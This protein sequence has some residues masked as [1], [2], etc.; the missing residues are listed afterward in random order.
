MGKYLETRTLLG[1][2]NDEATELSCFVNGHHD[3]SLDVMEFTDDSLVG[4]EMSVVKRIILN[5]QSAVKLSRML[6]SQIG[7]MDE[8]KGGNQNG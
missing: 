7:K 2:Q 5:R 1:C 4:G 3:I 6:R 8:L